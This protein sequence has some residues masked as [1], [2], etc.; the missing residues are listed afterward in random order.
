MTKHCDNAQDG[1]DTGGGYETLL[2]APIHKQR[3]RLRASVRHTRSTLRIPDWR[4]NLAASELVTS[5]KV[6]E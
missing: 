3:A 5:L 6:G 4:T 1:T 2:P